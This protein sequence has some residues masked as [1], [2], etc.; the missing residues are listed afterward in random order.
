MSG[1]DREFVGHFSYFF[2]GL[3]DSLPNRVPS[4][5]ASFQ[6]L[7]GHNLSSLPEPLADFGVTGGTGCGIGDLLGAV[8]VLEPGAVS[9]LD[10]VFVLGMVP[11]VVAV[12]DDGVVLG[13][14]DWAEDID[15]EGSLA[16][17]DVLAL[18]GLTIGAGGGVGAH[19]GAL[20]TGALALKA[21][22]CCG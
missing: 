12:G 11:E 3:L 8:S 7:S 14:E 1:D 21:G 17:A 6:K 2:D 22:C 10:E 15:D 19:V 20:G 18:G 13:L 16:L 5:L 4:G 9:V